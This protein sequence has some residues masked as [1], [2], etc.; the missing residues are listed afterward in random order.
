MRKFLL[1]ALPLAAA[2]AM[3]MTAV[4]ASAH[5]NRC[6]HDRVCMFEDPNYDGSLY[7]NQ[8]YRSN[9][10]FEID[11]WEGDNEISSV[12]NNTNASIRIYSNDGQ[13]G[14]WHCVGPQATRSNLA[15]NNFDNTAE[16]WAFASC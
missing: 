1:A 14:A 3:V 6:G 15:D 10:K 9:G 13:G 11:W 8:P 4:P 2:T 7:V 5:H 12:I 16:S